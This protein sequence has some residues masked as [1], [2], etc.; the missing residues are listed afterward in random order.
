[1]NSC[2]ARS[3]Y[4]YET[5]GTSSRPTRLSGLAA[6][7]VRDA[8]LGELGGGCGEAA[9]VETHEASRSYRSKRH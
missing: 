8:E 9:I 3:S 5:V 1:M 6:F 2:W 4:L 7:P